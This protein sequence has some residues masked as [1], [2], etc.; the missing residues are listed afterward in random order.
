MDAVRSTSPV[1]VWSLPAWVVVR[2]SQVP[3]SSPTAE[4]KRPVVGSSAA[5][6]GV[7]RH[8]G[9]APPLEVGAEGDADPFVPELPLLQ[10]DGHDDEQKERR[11]ERA[12]RVVV[13]R[14]QLRLLGRAARLEVDI[15]RQTRRNTGQRTPPRRWV[16]P[17]TDSTPRYHASRRPIWDD[18]RQEERGYDLSTKREMK[19]KSSPAL[20]PPR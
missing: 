3:R 17:H 19:G 10:H 9:A 20:S 13:R 2:G 1:R 5:A 8:D 6:E 7:A 14:L 15:A 12:E 11:E 4:K 16:N 18:E